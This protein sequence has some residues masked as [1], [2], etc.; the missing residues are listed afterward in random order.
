MVRGRVPPS[1]A[2]NAAD[3]LCHLD[4]KVASVRASTDNAPPP[5]LSSPPGCSIVEFRLLSVADVVALVQKLLYKQCDSD[6]IPTHLL[7]DC[8][9]ILDPFLVDMFNRSL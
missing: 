5:S 3:F 9:D 6:I 4:A 7:K 1:E 8:V 2:V